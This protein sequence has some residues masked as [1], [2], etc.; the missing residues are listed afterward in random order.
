MFVF[1]FTFTFTR[2]AKDTKPIVMHTNFV[3]T[4]GNNFEEQF[5]I[6]RPI[7]SK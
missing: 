1:Q 6:S 7:K 3:F 2:Q 4:V 5:K